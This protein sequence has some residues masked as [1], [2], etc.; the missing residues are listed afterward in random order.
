MLHILLQV[1]GFPGWQMK[2]HRDTLPSRGFHFCSFAEV[3]KPKW[4]TLN[5]LLWK[6]LLFFCIIIV[7]TG[8]VIL[9]LNLTF[10]LVLYPIFV[11]KSIQFQ[12]TISLLK[13]VSKHQ[14]SKSHPSL[15]SLFAWYFQ[16]SSGL[17][18]SRHMKQMWKAIRKYSKMSL[19]SLIFW[20]LSG[21][22]VYKMCTTKSLV[23]DGIVH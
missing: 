20:D 11:C 4:D 14:T 1:P 7:F 21:V 8:F 18:G 6:P 19:A 12:L 13:R 15:T 23:T 3:K 5:P 9:F 10:Y 2:T 16:Q 17:F 22:H